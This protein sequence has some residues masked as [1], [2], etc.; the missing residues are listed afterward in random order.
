MFCLL[1]YGFV[2]NPSEHLMGALHLIT[3]LTGLQSPNS[4]DELSVNMVGG[5]QVSSYCVALRGL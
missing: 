3:G 2:C 5:K 1:A 4:Y